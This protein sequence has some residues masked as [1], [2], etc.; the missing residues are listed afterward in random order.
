MG[1]MARF[2]VFC[3]ELCGS[4]ALMKKLLNNVRLGLELEKNNLK[5]FDLIL[6]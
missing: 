2:V 4:V 5:D 6:N 3:I 1:F